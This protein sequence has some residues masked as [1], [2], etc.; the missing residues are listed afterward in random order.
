MTFSGHYSDV[1]IL[2]SDGE[3]TAPRAVLACAYPGLYM[4]LRSQ[5]NQDLI[6]LLMP[7]FSRSEVEDHIFA[8]LAHNLQVRTCFFSLWIVYKLVYQDHTTVLGKECMSSRP[9]SHSPAP[10][11]TSR[12]AIYDT[13]HAAGS[14]RTF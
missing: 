6:T 4:V 2:C 7:K 11:L 5:Q 1:S 3:V 8:R 13:G 9:S 10:A 12:S 14:H